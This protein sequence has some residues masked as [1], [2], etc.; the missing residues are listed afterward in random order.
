MPWESYLLGGVE[1]LVWVRGRL[2]PG[3]EDMAGQPLDPTGRGAE[4][5]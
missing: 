2:G 3:E 1:T 4:S 5:E